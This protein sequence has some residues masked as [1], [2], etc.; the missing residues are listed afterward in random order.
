[1]G[2]LG[3]PRANR[4]LLRFLRFLR[5]RVGFRSGALL[6]CPVRVVGSDRR[7]T[8]QR[9]CSDGFRRRFCRRR[10]PRRPASCTPRR[11]PFRSPKRI[12]GCAFLS[13]LG[14]PPRGQ[15]LFER[16]RQFG[17]GEPQRL[18]NLFCAQAL[19]VL[20]QEIRNLVDDGGDVRQRSA[21]Q[22]ARVGGSCAT[23]GGRAQRP[24]ARRRRGGASHR[25]ARPS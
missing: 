6:P 14:E 3:P 12:P 2:R 5:K 11:G 8:C 16:P 25:L 13:G 1:M 7:V 20:R 21:G 18:T 17:G 4:V 22:T 19:T 10:G 9:R 24:R 15:P 23:R